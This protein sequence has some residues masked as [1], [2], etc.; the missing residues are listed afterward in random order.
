MISCHATNNMADYGEVSD[1]RK[2]EHLS[3]LGQCL[4]DGGHT[5]TYLTVLTLKNLKFQK[6]K[7]AA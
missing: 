7:I 6:S 4:P 3:T 1:S 5:L 2:S